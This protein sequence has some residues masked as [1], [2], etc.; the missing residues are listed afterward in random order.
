[1]HSNYEKYNE[2]PN[3]DHGS[4]FLFIVHGCDD[5]DTYISLWI[6]VLR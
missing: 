3:I 2:N 4:N 1:M 6:P 5:H